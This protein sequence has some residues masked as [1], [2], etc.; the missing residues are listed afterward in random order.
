LIEFGI[1]GLSNGKKRKFPSGSFQCKTQKNFTCDHCE[2]EFKEFKEK[3][4][5]TQHAQIHGKFKVEYEICQ[6]QVKLRTLRNRNKTIH[7]KVK[8]KCNV[9]ESKFLSQAHLNRHM[10][11]HQNH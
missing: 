11:F 1:F 7:Q 4:K 10:K 9:C 3:K 8:F 6:V 2:K 5:I